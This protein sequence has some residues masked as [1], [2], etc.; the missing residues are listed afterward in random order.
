[1]HQSKL[2]KIE[3]RKRRMSAVNLRDA[4]PGA[5]IDRAVLDKMLLA[6]FI[7]YKLERQD[8]AVAGKKRVVGPEFPP[9]RLLELHVDAGFLQ[10]LPDRAFRQFNVVPN[11]KIKLQPFLSEAG[12]LPKLAQ[13]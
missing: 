11:G 5:L 12:F 1:M 7:C 3:S 6:V 13:P 8:N 10:Q 2:D 9:V 4:Q